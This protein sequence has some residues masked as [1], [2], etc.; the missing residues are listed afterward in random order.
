MAEAEDLV[1]ITADIVAAHVSHN[2]VAVSDLPNL[3]QKVHEALQSVSGSAKAEQEGKNPVVSIRASIKPDYLI[4]LKCGRKQKVLRRHLQTAHGMTPETYRNDYGL[5]KSYPMVAA[6]YSE[7]RRELAQS[8]GL[9]RK[10]G[11]G[12]KSKTST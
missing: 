11:S 4:C 1:A 6:N 8:I 3:I 5:P 9:G 2:S 7:R 10:K 12:G